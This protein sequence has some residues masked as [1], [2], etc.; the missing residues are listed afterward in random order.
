MTFHE[1]HSNVPSSSIVAGTRQPRLRCRRLPHRCRRSGTVQQCL[2][3]EL[4]IYKM[5][6]DRTIRTDK[7]VIQN[8]R[9]VDSSS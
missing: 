7:K 8:I 5:I 2:E 1:S 9:P 4:H 6:F 3:K